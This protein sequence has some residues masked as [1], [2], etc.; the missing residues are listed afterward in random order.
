MQPGSPEHINIR[1]DSAQWISTD[2]DRTYFNRLV[3]QI[4]TWRRPGENLVI[5]DIAEPYAWRR[6]YQLLQA[7]ERRGHDKPAAEAAEQLG[8]SAAPETV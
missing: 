4:E 8:R 6:N 2:A 3:A 1:L 5:A 7:L